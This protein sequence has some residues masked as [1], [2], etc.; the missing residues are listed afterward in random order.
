MRTV[1]QWGEKTNILQGYWNN[2]Q[3]LN[4][5]QHFVFSLVIQ[6]IYILIILILLADIFTFRSFLSKQSDP[7]HHGI[8]TQAIESVLPLTNWESQ[9]PENL[10]FQLCVAMFYFKLGIDIIN[11]WRTFTKYIH[12]I[13][14]LPCLPHIPEIYIY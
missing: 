2:D 5:E 6:N 9:W 4:A 7:W 1:S 13:F 3:S 14:W 8:P 10:H 12:P 11:T